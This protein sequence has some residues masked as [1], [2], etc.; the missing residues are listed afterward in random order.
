MAS[1]LQLIPVGLASMH[2][3]HPDYFLV[4]LSEYILL[5]SL[6]NDLIFIINKGSLVGFSHLSLD[7][8]TLF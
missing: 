5:S 8:D 4:P 1:S 7:V 3:E 2:K 6:G